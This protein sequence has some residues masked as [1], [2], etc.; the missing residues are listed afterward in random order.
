MPL[1]TAHVA[2]ASFYSIWSA[3]RV[4]FEE[5]RGSTAFLAEAAARCLQ[6]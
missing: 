3:A 6:V 4:K 5:E 2:A 1:H